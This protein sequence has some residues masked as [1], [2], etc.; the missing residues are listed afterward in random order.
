MNIC[1]QKKG[2]LIAN[3]LNGDK[4][5]ALLI[6]TIGSAGHIAVSVSRDTEMHIP[7]VGTGTMITNVSDQDA[8]SYGAVHMIDPNPPHVNLFFIGQNAEAEIHSIQCT[9]G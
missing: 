6:V 1:A 8:V 3:Y 7:Y 5:P 4:S 9:L 2:E